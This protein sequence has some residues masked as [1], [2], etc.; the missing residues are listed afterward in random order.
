MSIYKRAILILYGICLCL[1]IGSICCVGWG[2]KV[3][4]M[5][6]RKGAGCEQV[7]D[8]TW[9]RI[10]DA[11]AP[12]GVRNVFRWTLG[13]LAESGECVGF[14]TSHQE[15]E[16]YID[17]RHV[18]HLEAAEGNIGRTTANQWIM[19]SLFQEDS[20]KEFRV[21]L[22]PVYA[23]VS[24]GAVPFYQGGELSVYLVSL[25]SSIVLIILSLVGIVVGIL[26]LLATICSLKNPQFDKNIWLLGAFSIGT[27]MWKLTDTYYSPLMFGGHELL[28]SY[29]TLTMLLVMLIPF[30][31]FVKTLLEEGKYRI[32]YWISAIE[33]AIAIGILVLQIFNILDLR[34]VLLFSHL[35]LATVLISVI[36]VMIHALTHGIVNLRLK[37]TLVDAVAAALGVLADM[38]IFYVTGNS[39]WAFWG[40]LG[41]GM[42][43]CTMGAVTI[44]AAL[45]VN[46]DALYRAEAA[47]RTKSIF[48]SNMSHDI[49]TPMNAII[50]FT[51]IAKN[52][53]DNPERLEDC[54]NKISTASNHLL[55]LINDVLDMSHIE[56]GKT[57][58]RLEKHNLRE[59]FQS[60]KD[61]FG[62][63]FAEKQ[64]QFNMDMEK[65]EIWD[66]YCDKL[67][68]NQ[69]IYNLL[70]NALKYT[71]S[72]GRVDMKVIQKTGPNP[73]RAYYEF[74]LKD[75]GVGMS[76][77]FTEHAFQMFERERNYTESNIQGNGLGLAIS[78]AIVDMAGG[79]IRVESELGKG[80]EFIIELNL[81]Y[82]NIPENQHQ[83][84]TISDQCFCDKRIL[85]VE[86][87]ELNREIA[88]E[89][90]EVLKL[91]VED[92]EDGIIAVE[93]VRQAESNPYDLILMDIQMPRMNGYQAAQAIR[94][95]DNPVLAAIPIIA[96]TANAFEEDR[97][98]AFE[99]G[100]DDHVAKPIDMD[101]LKQ[102]MAQILNK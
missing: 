17:N 78:K 37:V 96:M 89:L 95:L 73:E 56:S 61:I 99:A 31:L 2:N 34:E 55:S 93:K 47:N 9:D 18:Y 26:I 88:R 60:I 57:T 43:A 91:K 66:V 53:M 10:R 12:A 15:V 28:L 97:H 71:N 1:T 21:E 14:Y 83:Q 27:G 46:K 42:Y 86:D 92:A 59:M 101:V 24:D 75:T 36:F 90:L 35:S 81:K 33:A 98:R 25:S 40:M 70:S 41:F 65:V 7:L 4:E 32:L 19:I 77:E 72:G 45:L 11:S 102:A 74:H 30:N 48:L 62:E 29:I 68:M 3:D 44:R 16:V 76:P 6:L 38:I 84:A 20:G 23:G 87:N 52:E 54:L 100:M 8:Y 63:Q 58:L 22:S 80:T 5:H 64:I 82:V 39:Q 13:D 69:V 85:L 49:R 67:K 50:G 51:N 79:T 94:E